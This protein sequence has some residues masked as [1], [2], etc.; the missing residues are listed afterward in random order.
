MYLPIKL[1]F[2]QERLVNSAERKIS[3]ERGLSPMEL[4][5]DLNCR[6]V[7]SGEGKVFERPPLPLAAHPHL[8][9]RPVRLHINERPV[10]LPFSSSPFVQPASSP[11]LPLRFDSSARYRE[12]NTF[13]YRGVGP[14]SNYWRLIEQEG[15][16]IFW[17]EACN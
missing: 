1:L 14:L 11:F 4:H 16:E 5:A 15:E 2:S 9:F 8:F 17:I 10:D 6:F 12:G 3:A 7:E 13:P